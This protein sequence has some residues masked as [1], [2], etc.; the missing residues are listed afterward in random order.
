MFYDQKRTLKFQ[1]IVCLKSTSTSSQLLLLLQRA[2]EQKSE[3]PVGRK[4]PIFV[5][6]GK[7]TKL[8]D[9]F[10]IIED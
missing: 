1:I 9:I 4:R 3:A 10:L 6:S 5:I 8:A 7:V 2:V